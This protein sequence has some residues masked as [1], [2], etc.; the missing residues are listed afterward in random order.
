MAA[1][2]DIAL[3]KRQEQELALPAFDEHIAFAIGSAIR[4]RARA[5]GLGLVVD[6]RTWDRQMF[7]SATPG[8]GPDN[9]EWVRRK[10][11]T[12]RRFHKGHVSDRARTQRGK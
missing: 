7:F 4:E 12:V 11:N 3:I 1:A 10:I 8:S 2:D 6:L 5:E 9:A